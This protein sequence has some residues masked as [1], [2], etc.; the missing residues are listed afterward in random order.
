MVKSVLV[1]LLMAIPCF[2]A[3]SVFVPDGGHWS[4][5][6]HFR[7]DDIVQAAT[8]DTTAPDTQSASISAAKKRT[9]ENSAAAGKRPWPTGALIRSALLPGWG[10]IYNRKYLKAAF[11]G[12]LEI[13]FLIGIR[14][15]WKE[16]NL[17]QENFLH[18]NDPVFKSAEFDLYQDSRDRRNVF[19]WLGALTIFVSMFDAYV[20]AHFADFDKTDKA[21]EVRVV[22][23]DDF[24]A[25]TLTCNFR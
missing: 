4:I 1:G 24:T 5:S 2:A 18:T 19:L 9:P 17:H 15:N 11:Y 22:P 3:Q 23:G 8:D 12:G 25:I 14:E 7:N 6:R 13:Y 21:F 10:Q 20:D 16:M